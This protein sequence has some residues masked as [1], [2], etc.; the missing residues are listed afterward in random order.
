MTQSAAL[1]VEINKRVSLTS[2]NRFI[3]NI[4]Y[5][6]TLKS[7]FE[8]AQDIGYQ[9]ND[10]VSVSVG[11][12]NSGDTLKSDAKS[13]NVDLINENTSTLSAGVEVVY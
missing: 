11:H 13:S 9:V 12:S 10:N 7:S 2:T 4:A 6:G 8:L 3:S 5:S 1:A